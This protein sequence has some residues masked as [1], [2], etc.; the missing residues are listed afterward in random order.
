MVSPSLITVPV[1]D[2]VAV[3]AGVIFCIFDTIREL[4]FD[5][6]PNKGA[7]DFNNGSR[8]TFT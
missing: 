6:F 5:G 1:T 3:L 7:I 8:Q 4:R 2:W